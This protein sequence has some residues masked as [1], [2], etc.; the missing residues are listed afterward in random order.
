MDKLKA[1]LNGMFTEPN[2]QTPCIV[3]I[4]SVVGA[5]QGLGLSGYT[6]VVQHAAFDLQAF[7][8]GLGAMIGG[9]GIALGMKK[10]SA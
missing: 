4:V 10:D 7:G 5:V 3:R 1:F 2:N 9:L 8:I 6:V